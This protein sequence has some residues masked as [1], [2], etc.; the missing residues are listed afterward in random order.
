MLPLPTDSMIP[1]ETKPNSCPWGDVDTNLGVGWERE[2]EEKMG[3]ERA[4]TVGWKTA[5]DK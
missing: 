4:K 3:A 5:V 1:Q 2:G